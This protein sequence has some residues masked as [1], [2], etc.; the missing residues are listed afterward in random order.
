MR[1]GI[2]CFDSANF[3]LILL[4]SIVGYCK[5]KS[6]L[7]QNSH[8]INIFISD[9]TDL[10]SDFISPAWQIKPTF[11]F[12]ESLLWVSARL[13]GSQRN[14]ARTS[15]TQHISV[16]PSATQHDST[17]LNVTQ[18]DSAR[19]SETQR[20]SARLSVTQRDSAQLSATQ[21][22]SA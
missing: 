17:R 15:V 5:K 16:R 14:P 21:R 7:L 1:M 20:D 2:C 9:R 8:N 19:L 4:D 18:R 6:K 10:F 22:N 11:D 3:D 12:A 13:C